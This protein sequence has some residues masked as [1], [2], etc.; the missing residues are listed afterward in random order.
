MRITQRTLSQ[1]SLAGINRNLTQL[2]KLQNQLTSG[3]S[4]NQPSDSPTGTNSSLQIRSALAANTQY[5]ANM[6]DGKTWLSTADTT[7]KSMI[8]QAQRVRDL[9]VQGMNTGAMSGADREVIGAEVAQLHAGL[10]GLANTQLQ[11]RPLFG[12]ATGGLEAYAVTTDPATGNVTGSTFVGVESAG[13][14]RRI[15]DSATVRVNVTGAE[16]FAAG[17][18]DDLFSVVGKISKALATDPAGLS[19]QLGA[20]DDAIS[21]M[22]NALAS[23][24]ARSQRIDNAL[25]ANSDQILALT[26]QQ[27]TVEDVDMPKTIMALSLQQTGYQAALSVASKSLQTSLVDFLR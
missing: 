18:N 14:T 10:L 22:T 7:L 6:G 2:N 17:T 21:S 3:K 9:T 19:A 27:S 1:N 13:V 25:Q 4:L 26:A 20:L 11:G 16:A 23:V 24:G 15:T 8:S 12:G 5:A